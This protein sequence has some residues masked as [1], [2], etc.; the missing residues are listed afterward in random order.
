MMYLQRLARSGWV[1]A[2]FVSSGVW[3]EHPDP[4][5]PVL[6]YGF[7][8]LYG[9]EV[10]DSMGRAH[11]TV[12]GSVSLVDGKRRK[13][14]L[15]GGSAQWVDTPEIDL[16]DRTWS[17]SA[18]FR[19]EAGPGSDTL[20]LLQQRDGTA[21]GRTWLGVKNDG[22]TF[23]LTSY[24]GGGESTGGVVSLNTWHHAAVVSDDGTIRLY[25]DGTE[26]D[27]STLNLEL[28][29]A[30]F[31]IGN[32]KSPGASHQ[33]PGRMDDVALYNRALTQA[34]IAFLV[35]DINSYTVLHVDTGGD[36]GSGDGSAGAPFASLGK[37]LEEAGPLLVAGTP[38][39][40]LVAEGIYREGEK[41]WAVWEYGGQAA[42][43]PLVM[44]GMHKERT[45][46]SG[47]VVWENG[48]TLHEPGVWR[49]SWTY[50]WGLGPNPWPNTGGS[51]PD[52][53]RRREMLIIDGI[54][55]N[56][57]F[58]YGDLRQDT[59][60]VD[61]AT[62][63]IYFMGAEPNGRQVE[64]PVWSHLLEMR[65]KSNLIIRNLT[66]QHYNNTPGAIS[67]LRLWGQKNG[68]AFIRSNVVVEDCR[69]LAN[70]ANALSLS[71]IRGGVVRRCRF[72]DNGFL[73][74][75]M[76]QTR[77]S[78]IEAVESHRANWRG[79]PQNYLSWSTGAAKITSSE[80]MTVSGFVAGQN[81]TNGF[82]FDIENRRNHLE[83]LHAYYNANNAAY[84]EF[85]EGPLVMDGAWLGAN[86]AAILLGETTHAEIRNVVALENE[87]TLEIRHNDRLPM[88]SLV[89]EDNEWANSVY[90][91]YL[92]RQTGSVDAAEWSAL[93]PG[94]TFR[95]NRY[96][97]ASDG[98]GFRIPISGI[99]SDL[100]DW[101]GYLDSSGVPE[102]KGDENAAEAALPLDGE[103]N[104][105]F[106]W[107]IWDDL[108]SATL[109]AL[110][111]DTG[112]QNHIPDAEEIGWVLERRIG[113]GAPFGQR[114]T[115]LLKAAVDGTY[116]FRL[117]AD[118]EAELWVSTD[119]EGSG[120]VKALEQTS[121]TFLRDPG[122]PAYEILL[123]AGD[124]L[125][126]QVLH[127]G[128]GPDSYVSVMFQRPDR[129]A[130]EPLSAVFLTSMLEVPHQIEGL[131]GWFDAQGFQEADGTDVTTWPDR[132]GLVSN[133][134]PNDLQQ[135]TGLT[136]TPVAPTLQTVSLNGYSYRSVRFVPGSS[137]DYELLR[138]AGLVPDTDN[139]RSIVVVYK[140]GVD[141]GG[142][143]PAG[144]GSKL[145]D[146]LDTRFHWNLGTDGNG[147]LRFDGGFI[148]PYSVSGLTRNDVLIRVAEMEG[149]NRYA[150]H[151]DVLDTGFVDN[152]VLVNGSLSPAPSSISGDFY[153]GDLQVS[154]A[155]G[156]IGAATYDILEVLVYDRS[157]TDGE[158]QSI[159][160]YLVD[161]YTSA[162]T[163]G[164]VSPDSVA[165][166]A[167]SST[168]I[169]V[170]WRDVAINETGYRIERSSGGA[171]S[172]VA[173]V[174]AD[175]VSYVH[176]NP[177]LGVFTYRVI[178]LGPGGESAP[179][180]SGSTSTLDSDSDGMLDDHEI[181]AGSD[182]GQ[183]SSLFELTPVVPLTGLIGFSAP[184]ASG[185]HYRV[186]YR[187][188]LQTGNWQILNDYVGD[189]TALTVEDSPANIRFYKIEASASPFP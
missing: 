5:A 77:N 99:P 100:D 20:K 92:I 38:V 79:Y 47:A 150:E 27:T 148:G 2:F 131:V 132:T 98:R 29:R 140:G 103:T 86:H 108:P 188:S 33:W 26:V 173:M 163:S 74:M 70:G 167:V 144:F 30:P 21:T 7:D 180:T 59:Y 1:L 93:V 6:W 105:P 123:T 175:T 134:E 4:P 9:P 121:P 169:E 16:D 72:D 96:T 159:Q 129:A 127:A 110:R 126:L 183:A 155:G 34:D 136:G 61:E 84:L 40:I 97:H 115:T 35:T 31:R 166:W 46:F 146:G 48:W 102:G 8:G 184:T 45:V 17:A 28:N 130:Y 81:L 165:A 63:R 107:E 71:V 94:L 44:E 13:G 55:M 106:V 75:S 89:V 50:D 170:T 83:D 95:D 185:T 124:T 24:L 143:R 52:E 51:L 118:A 10:R 15:V 172:L 112:F 57:V 3:G 145:V 156:Q 73:N 157:L 168:Q 36:D 122:G 138:F 90:F 149:F 56:P 76:S 114:G 49:H 109:A 171:F 182:P 39:R 174:S 162:P 88:T 101:I 37:A 113:R 12:N 53:M 58:A 154:S 42:D 85:S 137:G 23:R 54:R 178:A 164:P 67:T 87:D 152:A 66:F 62:D 69:F 32:F 147:S 11:G 135:M 177:G 65:G 60:F 186:W 116:R 68:E 139:T 19:L 181:L 78:R 82:W 187:V 14:I 64:V 125:W 25:L 119:P 128:A 141:S 43:T 176:V 153:L 160:T 161:K 22:G 41:F 104:R 117:S 18:W 151:I 111:E 179:G 120:A 91:D 158:R 142:S 133:R 189:G 80:E